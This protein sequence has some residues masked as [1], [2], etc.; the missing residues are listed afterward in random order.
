M[1]LAKVPIK[2]LASISINSGL[3]IRSSLLPIYGNKV[4]CK[5][6]TNL[7]VKTA[8]PASLV[9]LFILESVKSFSLLKLLEITVSTALI[10][11]SFLNVESGSFAASLTALSNKA[12]LKSC[13]AFI[14]TFKNFN[15]FLSSAIANSGK[16]KPT[17][18]VLLFCISSRY[19]I[20]L[21][22]ASTILSRKSFGT[23][24]PSNSWI[25]L[26]LSMILSSLI[27][28]KAASA[29]S[30]L[31]TVLSN[32]VLLSLKVALPISILVSSPFLPSIVI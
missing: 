7:S 5:P 13:P 23:T 16:T 32:D 15:T 26:N 2:F 21:S 1:P 20:P 4:F 10:S 17:L 11:P 3:L 29:E 6:F 14:P 31:I 18:K 9:A 8:S 22:R 30:S 25:C 27:T 19:L 12:L 28:S 24:L